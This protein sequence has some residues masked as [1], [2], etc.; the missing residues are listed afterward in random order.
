MTVLQLAQKLDATI[1]CDADVG[2]TI[3]GGYA[4]DLLSF[5]MGKA[6]QDC[7]WFTVMTN[8][9]VCAVATLTEVSVVVVCEGCKPDQILI[10]RCQSQ[11]VNLVVTQLDM[12]SAIAKVANLLQ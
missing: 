4:G 10:D 2:K 11:G 8:V 1:V 6:T 9:N 5:V 7:A 3:N 12:F